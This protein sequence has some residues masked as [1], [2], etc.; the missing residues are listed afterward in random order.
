M[1][2]EAGPPDTYL[3]P[4]LRASPTQVKNVLHQTAV[5]RGVPHMMHGPVS[6]SGERLRRCAAFD[7]IKIRP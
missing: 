3:P 2:A 7:L 1:L 4:S 5:V 6:T